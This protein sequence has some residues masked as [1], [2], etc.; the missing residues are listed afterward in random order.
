M[1]PATHRIG[2]ATASFGEFRGFRAAAALSVDRQ[3]SD[4]LG[5]ESFGT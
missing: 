1:V 5:T 4:R 2:R 3:M